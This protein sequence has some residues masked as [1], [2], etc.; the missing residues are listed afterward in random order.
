M[1]TPMV[2]T[3][4]VV[5]PDVRLVAQEIREENSLKY[6][7]TLAPT[8]TDSISAGLGWNLAIYS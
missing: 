3:N 2:S 8:H 6:R 5:W 4:T 1:S 7:L